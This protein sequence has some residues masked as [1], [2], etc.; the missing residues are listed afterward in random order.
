MI[1][2]SGATAAPSGQTRLP[3]DLPARTG[4]A[5]ASSAPRH[6]AWRVV[7]MELV[8]AALLIPVIIVLVA[9]LPLFYITIPL[10]AQGERA[11]ARLCG[12][13][14]SSARPAGTPGWP[15]LV[16]R[17]TSAGF[18]KQD[19]P[20]VVIGLVM[21][22]GSFVI[23]VSGLSTA[24]VLALVPWHTTPENPTTI[25]LG[26]WATTQTDGTRMGWAVVLAL[27]LLA[28]TWLLLWGT[29]ALRMLLVRALSGQSEEERLSRANAALSAEVGHLA[30]GRATLVDAFDAERAR[31]ERDLHDGVQQDLVAV[32]MS[33]GAVR[34]QLQALATGAQDDG[35]GTARAALLAGLDSAQERAEAAMRS[36]RETVRGIRPAVL[37]ERGLAPALRDLAGRAPL[38]T[39]VSVRGEAAAGQTVSSPVATAVYFAVSEALTNAAKHAGPQARA[40]VALEVQEDQLRAVVTDDG[41]GGASPQ[42]PGATGLAGMAQRVESVG[43]TL[44][45]VSP[46]GGGT[47]LT[48][49][50]PLTPPWARGE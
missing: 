33:I 19:L 17:V 6:R 14:V 9:G 48:I 23:A 24:A 41:V 11:A 18:W 25:V 45:V 42:A 26:V 46:S 13:D 43:G 20:M 30:A 1:T 5:A 32:T 39:T 34:M 27:A 3:A 8:R 44:D 38:P 15:W 35:D 7:V 2:S 47:R 37:T 28:L 49:T 22:L 40:V 29:G 4:H 21:S 16:R 31:I 50:A 12:L 36:L 10:T